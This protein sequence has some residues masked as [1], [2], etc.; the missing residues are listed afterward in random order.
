MDARRR[1]FTLIELLV[2]MVIISMLVGLLLPAL[3]RAQEE[4]RKTQCRSNLRQ[5]G[6][7]MVM[8]CSDNSGFTPAAYGTNT[9][10]A[11]L[12]P[13]HYCA[14]R[15]R[16]GT[17][18]ESTPSGLGF[19]SVLSPH[20]Y[21]IAMFD[22]AP[23]AGQFVGDGVISDNDDRWDLAGTFPTGSGGGIPSGLG[24]LFTG[25]YLTQKGA[26]VLDC[27]S[28]T[29]YPGKYD[30]A[31]V[32]GGLSQNKAAAFNMTVK[33][34]VQYDPKEPLWTTAGRN[35]WS[36]G[37]MIGEMGWDNMGGPSTDEVGGYWRRSEA[38]VSNN[39]GVWSDGDFASICRPDAYGNYCWIIGSYQVR[40][41]GLGTR[42]GGETYMTYNSWQKQLMGGQAVASDAILGFFPRSNRIRINMGSGY[43]DFNYL[44]SGVSLKQSTYIAS[45]DSSYNAL[46]MDGAVKTFG[47][48]GSEIYKSLLLSAQAAQAAC[49]LSYTHYGLHEMAKIYDLYFDPLYAQD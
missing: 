18:Y 38:H 2:V 14:A 23:T 34:R 11:S 8:Y 40:P 39:G 3:G 37:N 32:A 29:G 28:M 20:S 21:M 13:E 41:D 12:T 7:A 25:G 42:P 44:T 33:E 31:L 5:I 26:S 46:F 16:W 22:A 30:E 49:G 4:A 24:L 9:R 47:D 48:A 27:P 17:G 45:H 35:R 19:S 1:G 36:N 43:V 10:K 6:L 15:H